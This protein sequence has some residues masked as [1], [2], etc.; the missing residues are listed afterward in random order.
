MLLNIRLRRC[1][2]PAWRNPVLG[3]GF[4]L[5][6]LLIND[7]IAQL[8]QGLTCEVRSD[9]RFHMSDDRIKLFATLRQQLRPTV[10]ASGWEFAGINTMYELSFRDILPEHKHNSLPQCAFQVL[11]S[12]ASSFHFERC[13]C[14]FINPN[15]S[16]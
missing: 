12:G 7:H 4:Q 2:S 5:R 16:M 15:A 6:D 10:N 8:H 1:P 3:A 9:I 14:H 13:F 11:V